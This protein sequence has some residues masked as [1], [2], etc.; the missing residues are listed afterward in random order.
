MRYFLLQ[1][2][3][4]FFL[5]GCKQKIEPKRLTDLPSTQIIYLSDYGARSGDTI[6]DT[7]AI[8][9]ALDLASEDNPVYIV[10][11]GHYLVDEDLSFDKSMTV[12]SRGGSIEY[13]SR[14]YFNNSDTATFKG[15]KEASKEEET[16]K[17]PSVKLPGSF[18][19]FTSN[20]TVSVDGSS[21]EGLEIDGKKFNE[22]DWP[23]VAE[24]NVGETLHLENGISITRN[25]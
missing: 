5:I 18:T 23:K 20:S 7:R 24:L 25:N 6:P 11:D 15:D 16:V 4:L 14:L 17:T 2:I 13:N 21:V 19:V 10:V 12:I 22:S 1:I 8:K 9:D 3:A